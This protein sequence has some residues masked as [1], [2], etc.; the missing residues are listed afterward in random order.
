MEIIANKERSASYPASPYKLG[1]SVQDELSDYKHALDHSS[2]VAIADLAGNITYVNEQFCR[3]SK[4][5]K[6]ELIGKNHRILKSGYHPDSFYQEMWTTIASG[7][8]WKGEVKNKAK[9]GSFYWVFTTIVP[10]VSE[11][12]KPYQYMSIRTDITELKKVEEQIQQEHLRLANS[13]KMASLGEIAAGI[14]HEL[15]TPISTIRGRAELL[16]MQVQAGNLNQENVLK[17]TE[18]I[19]KLVDQMS[20]I[21]RGMKALSRDGSQDPFD[22]VKI[23]EI[24]KDILEF[25]WERN[26]KLGIETLASEIDEDSVVECR[27]T[28]I[29]QVL[30]NLLNNAKDAVKDLEERW[31]K[32]ET[33]N[34]GHFFEISI[35]DSGK[36]IPKEIAKRIMDPFFTTKDVGHGTG[37]GLSISKTIIE[38][39]KGE[40]FIDHNCKNT[41]FVVRLPLK[42]S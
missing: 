21:I 11:R 18:T 5:K 36:G 42:Q 24:L 16:E 33:Q 12:G 6:E 28:Q 41:K 37:L 39:H 2:I 31:I 19:K 1:S 22:K 35:T 3:I 34:N 4:F 29:S 30:V 25:S 40:F 14:A 7:R 17:V 9:D 32:L 10:F 8:V 23:G 20:R 38:S 26:K 13:E 27:Q 15:G